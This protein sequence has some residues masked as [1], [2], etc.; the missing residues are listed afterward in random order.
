VPDPIAVC[1]L[2][3]GPDALVA[4]ALTAREGFGLVAMFADYGQRTVARERECARRCARWLSC[5][6][7]REATVGWLA[8]IG[9]SVLT[10]RAGRV[11]RSD[12]R[13]EYV[14]FRNS[15]LLAHA[16]AW[17]EVLGAER[18]V[19]GSTG[20]DRISPDNSPAYLAAFQQVVN[21]GT[22]IGPARGIT[23]SAPL[24]A[25]TKSEMIRLGIGLGAPFA[26][27]WSCQNDG[28]AACGECNN[29]RAR[30]A[31][32]A[33]HGLADP[34]LEAAGGPVHRATGR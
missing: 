2:S 3:G 15:L 31:A 8:D 12:V 16:V 1:L 6:E 33:Q 19:I 9:G 20:S 10:A 5:R 22:M 13:A 32:F 21:A 11:D 4:A 27:T 29:C 34:V 7:F 23:V 24:A 26:D 17:A 28:D 14:P 30:E 18:V 25:C